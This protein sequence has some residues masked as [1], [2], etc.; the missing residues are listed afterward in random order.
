MKLAI[1][2][3]L[4]GSQQSTIS[5]KFP[6]PVID[7]LL[8]ELNG[9]TVF[10]KIDLKLRYHQIRVKAEDIPKTAFRTHKGH[11][12]FLIMPFGLTNAPA[13]FQS[14]MNTV[15]RNQLRRYISIF[16]DDILVYSYTEVKHRDHLR[17][18]MQI[19]VNNQLYVNTKKC[20]FGQKE[21]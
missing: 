3:K 8:D 15:F 4:S 7:E 18:V 9:A 16:F 1:L 13:T 17:M 5:H 14:L 2:C 20:S 11:Y 12:E 10:S 19:I 6:T 21:I